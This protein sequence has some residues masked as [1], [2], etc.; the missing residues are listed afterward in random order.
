[1]Q[2]ELYPQMWFFSR[3]YS[4][5]IMLGLAA[6]GNAGPTNPNTNFWLIASGMLTPMAEMLFIPKDIMAM[7]F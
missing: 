4:A 1:M 2:S 6:I 7:P 5:N 3:K